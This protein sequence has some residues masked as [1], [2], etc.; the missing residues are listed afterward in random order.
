M[1]DGI[2]GAGLG[3]LAALDALALVDV[4]SAVLELDGTLGTDLLA[5]AGKAVLAVLGD[6]VLIGRAGMA[7][8]GND[9]D[10]RRL[11][12]LLRHRCRIHA[13]GDQMAAIH[14]AQGQSHGQTHPLTG[15]GTLQKDGLPVQGTVAGDDLIGQVICGINAVARVGHAG[16]LG[17]NVLSNVR[18]QGRNSSHSIPPKWCFRY[19]I[20][21]PPGNPV[22][23]Q[24]RI[25][26][27]CS[28]I[29]L[30]FYLQVCYNV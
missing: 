28:Q 4:R 1:N 8:I 5:G 6:L 14:G 12:V 21:Y 10:E 11:I 30:L 26:G 20:T 16:N 23:F 25:P 7:G 19:F 15:N 3:T 22:L 2:V 17:E 9:V 24:Q 18:N 27:N 13:L 29:R